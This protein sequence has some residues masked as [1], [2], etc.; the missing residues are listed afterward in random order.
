M[1][2]REIGRHGGHRGEP[3]VASVE[4]E[5]AADVDVAHAV[6]VGHHEACRRRCIAGDPLDAA[7]GH[8]FRPVSASVTWKSCSR[9]C[10]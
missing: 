9:G 2:K 3:P 5:Q 10:R 7:A 8:G 6:A 4:F 1:P